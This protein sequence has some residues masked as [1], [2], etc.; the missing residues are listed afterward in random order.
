MAQQYKV[1]LCF[2]ARAYE[3][4]H[5]TSE[6]WSALPASRSYPC[7]LQIDMHAADNFPAS[8]QLG[9]TGRMLG[10]LG[11]PLALA[12]LPLTAAAMLLVI[13]AAPTAAAVA[14]RRDR[15]EGAPHV[16]DAWEHEAHQRLIGCV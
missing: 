5:D 3:C 2:H 6:H 7:R 9:F 13:A 8:V 1:E 4:A 11:L 15:P 12:A 14:W 16:N 10:R